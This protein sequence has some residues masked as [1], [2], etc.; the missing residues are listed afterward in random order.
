MD[1]TIRT[2]FNTAHNRRKFLL[3]SNVEL[4]SS[5]SKD[6]LRVAELNDKIELDQ[7]AIETFK[8]I[9]QELSLVHIRKIETLV[10]EAL[11]AIFFDQD[12]SF[13]VDITDFA[14]KKSAK[15]I[16]S[17]GGVEVNASNSGGG[18]RKVIGFILRLYFLM[19]NGNAR[20]MFIDEAFGAISHRY[21]DS[22]LSFL[23]TL[24]DKY[25][26][27]FIMVNHD[28]RFSDAA[29]ITYTFDNGT[30]ANVDSRNHKE[31]I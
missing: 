27:R 9:S 5:I 23:T 12:L 26:F 22:F 18:R 19:K 29:A 13:K 8:F 16:V 3:D 31:E 4:A 11:R 28:P 20:I 14:N 24:V 21:V 15:M 10:T 7:Q 25:N 1:S 30:I 2:R 17:N 6:T